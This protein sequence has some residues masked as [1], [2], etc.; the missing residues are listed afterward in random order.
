MSSSGPESWTDLF[1]KSLGA[2]E[3]SRS[4]P[5]AR[6]DGAPTIPR[7]EIRER[8]GEGATA[9]VYRA[10]DRELKRTIALKVLR[11]RAAMSDVLR[12]RFHREAQATAGL[13]HAHVIRVHDAGEHRGELYLVLEFVSGRSLAH[14]LSERRFSERESASLLE[15]VARGIAAAHANGVVH[16]DLKPGNILV[17]EPGEP[18]VGDFGLAHVVDS[19]TTRLTQTGSSLGTPLYMAPEQVEG[20]WRE[21]SPRTDV[22]A[23]GA[24]LYEMLSG[25]PPHLGATPAEI[26]RRILE[27]EVE[28]LR[29]LRPEVSRDLEKIALK[30]LEKDPRARYADAREFADE[31]NRFQ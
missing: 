22:Y 20:R 4:K 11:G 29:N 1:L 18:K 30:A 25:R 9:V 31:L 16:R 14:L 12:E 24:V 19:D 21:I 27:V 10:W 15:K 2:H 6:V 13:D 7:Y 26:Y 17:T 8:V 28:P 5:G 3:A 23:L